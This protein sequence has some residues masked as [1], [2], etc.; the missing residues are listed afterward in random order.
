[1]RHKDPIRVVYDKDI[2]VV[3]IMSAFRY[4]SLEHGKILP[5]D[6]LSA[7]TQ[8]QKQIDRPG[9]EIGSVVARLMRLVA[10]LSREHGLIATVED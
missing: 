10:L 1:M 8:K 9:T 2:E 5:F 7:Y 6:M 3:K 4:R